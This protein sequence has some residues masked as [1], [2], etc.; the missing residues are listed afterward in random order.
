MKEK[1]I[2]FININKFSF[3][4]SENVVFCKTD[5]ILNEFSSIKKNGKNIILIT[6]NSDYPITDFHVERLPK[7]VLKWYAQNALSNAEILECIPTGLENK[8]KCNRDGHGVSY[9][10][11]VSEKEKLLNRDLNIKPNKFIYSNFNIQTNVAERTK[12]LNVIKDIK[13][14]DWENGGLTLKNFFNKILEYKMILCPVGNG[15]DTHRLW[16]VL[17]SNRVPIT[18]KVGNY[19]IYNLYKQLPI[20]VLDN[21]EQLYDLNLLELEYE[22]AYSK[23]NNIYISEFDYWKNKILNH[24]R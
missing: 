7:N 3:L 19:N 21:Y 16:E 5:F 14:I 4:Q 8:D 24:D 1:N 13:H 6:G 18:I 15:V 12:C 11:L 20:I 2:D 22:K 23:F 17:Y 9:Y 10:D